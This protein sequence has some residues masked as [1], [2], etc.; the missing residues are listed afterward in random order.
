MKRKTR[1]Q[2]IVEKYVENLGENCPY[3][4]S[5]KIASGRPEPESP[6]LIFRLSRCT[7]CKK[8]WDKTFTLT[9]IKLLSPLPE[10]PNSI[11]FIKSLKRKR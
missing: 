5:D 7:E 9:S 10:I 2:R 6:A 11:K 1:E 8:E 3:C 4:G